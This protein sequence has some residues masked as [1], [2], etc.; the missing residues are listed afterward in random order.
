MK[1]LKRKRLLLA[2]LAFVLLTISFQPLGAYER[3]YINS[4]LLAILL[5]LVCLLLFVGFG[6]LALKNKAQSTRNGRKNNHAA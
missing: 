5:S 4:P 2:V 6:L 3:G 1:R